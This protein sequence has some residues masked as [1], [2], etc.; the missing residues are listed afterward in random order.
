MSEIALDLKEVIR[1]CNQEIDS[2]AQMGTDDEEWKEGF[3]NG[4]LHISEIFQS[5][6]KQALEEA[7]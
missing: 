4:M 2:H 6:Q 1:V 7:S 3:I 5:I